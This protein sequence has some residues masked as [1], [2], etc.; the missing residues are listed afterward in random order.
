MRANGKKYLKFV[1]GGDLDKCLEQIKLPISLC[2][3]TPYSELPSNTNTMVAVQC[4]PATETGVS[5]PR[6]DNE[7][8]DLTLQ[9]KKQ[10][11]R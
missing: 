8:P 9:N 1:T 5:D 6:G 10:V 11:P 3:C 2:S 4:A 7:D